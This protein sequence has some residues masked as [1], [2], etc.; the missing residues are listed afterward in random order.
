MGLFTTTPATMAKRGTLNTNA[1]PQNGL[2]TN[3]NTILIPSA[4]VIPDAGSKFAPVLPN[5]TVIS[6]I[7]DNSA[8]GTNTLFGG[9]LGNISLLD[10]ATITSVLGTS[11][12]DG[13]SSGSGNTG[14][15]VNSW[16]AGGHKWS[17]NQLLYSNSSGFGITQF[18]QNFLI[19]YTNYD[20][21][22]QQKPLRIS[23]AGD[24]KNLNPDQLKIALNWL[25]DLSMVASLNVVA[26]NIVEL[27][28]TGN[29]VL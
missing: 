8:S 19:G 11:C 27:V 26:G 3:A 4:V 25:Y 5:T 13:T 1:K 6:Y 28:F 29:A 22:I 2:N 16:T 20:S 17:I 21:T 18:P 23:Q 7:L 15:I 14:D 12:S 9:L 24:P 10:A